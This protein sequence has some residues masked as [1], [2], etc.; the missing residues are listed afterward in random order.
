MRGLASIKRLRNLGL[1]LYSRGDEATGRALVMRAASLRQRRL[2]GNLEQAA[3]DAFAIAEVAAREP[4]ESLRDAWTLAYELGKDNQRVKSIAASRLSSLAYDDGRTDRAMQL[5][6]ESAELALAHM[7]LESFHAF[8]ALVLVVGLARRL[9]EHDRAVHW[10]RVHLEQERQKQA[11]KLGGSVGSAHWTL[12]RSA[13]GIR[14][15]PDLDD[16]YCYGHAQSVF[17]VCFTALGEVERCL[18]LA[19]KEYLKCK[20]ANEGN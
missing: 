20:F 14:E 15:L 18:K 11:A 10:A 5:A 16:D 17:D 2:P 9:G 19:Q 4:L 6:E 8:A 1:K 7:T 3:S 13:A 12:S